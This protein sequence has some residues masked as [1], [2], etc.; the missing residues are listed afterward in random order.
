MTPRVAWQDDDAALFP[1]LALNGLVEVVA[2]V[3]DVA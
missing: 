2:H 3:A 1:R